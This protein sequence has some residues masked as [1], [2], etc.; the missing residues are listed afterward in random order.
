[1]LNAARLNVGLESVA[2]SERAYQQALA[3]AVDRVQGKPPGCREESV[4]IIRHPDVRRMLLSMR[5]QIEAMR[6]L[7]YII[8]ASKDLAEHHPDATLRAQR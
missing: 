6:G 2:V 5:S 1:M 4:S 8:A 3:Y 7:A